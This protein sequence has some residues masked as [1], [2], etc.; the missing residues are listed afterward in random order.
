MTMYS[1]VKF[2]KPSGIE[3]VEAMLVSDETV[4][5]AVIWCGGEV[6]AEVKPGD[7]EAVS[8]HILVPTLGGVIKVRFGDYLVQDCRGRYTSMP[9]EIFE[10]KFTAVQYLR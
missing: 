5:D 7:P 6:G 10:K 9:A 4:E 1:H 3:N 8:R 2:Y